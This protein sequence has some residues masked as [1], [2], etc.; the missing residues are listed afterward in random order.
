MKTK[1][2]L[3][4]AGV[5]VVGI[6]IGVREGWPQISTKPAEGGPVII[7]SFAVERGRAGIEWRIYLEAED[8]AGQMDRIAAVVDQQGSG[9]PPADFVILKGTDRKHFKG[10][11]TWNT[12]SSK[13]ATMREWTSLVLR[14]SV[15]DKGGRESNEVALPFTFESGVADPGMPPAPFDVAGLPKLGNLHFDLGGPVLPER[16]LE[17]P[18]RD[19]KSP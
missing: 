14:V 19:R 16:L 9:R 3:F 18:G 11:L 2:S 13:A 8:P 17:R 6:F 5:L 4:V 12:V 1:R 10:Y 7:H 15:M